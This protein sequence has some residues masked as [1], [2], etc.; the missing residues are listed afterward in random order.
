[1]QV[2][3]ANTVLRLLPTPAGQVPL[4]GLYLSERFAP[5]AKPS[6]SFVYANFIT[7][8]DGRISLPD[9]RTSKRTAPRAITNPRDWR[10]FQELAAC[11]ERTPRSASRALFILRP[12]NDLPPLRDTA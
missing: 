9:P 1:M 5:P 7:S 11:L 6:R 10:L 2:A 12:F 4:H 3:D 8:L